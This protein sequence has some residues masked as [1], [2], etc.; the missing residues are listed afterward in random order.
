MRLFSKCLVIKIDYK[1]YTT[2]CKRI[3]E[4]KYSFSYQELKSINLIVLMV[5]K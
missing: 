4:I 5:S 3:A 2:L 1:Y